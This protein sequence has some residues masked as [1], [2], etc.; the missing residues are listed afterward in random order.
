MGL[1]GRITKRQS[2]EDPEDLDFD[3]ETVDSLDMPGEE[4]GSRGGILR[5][6]S[7]AAPEGGVGGR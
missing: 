3:D 1:L 2:A 4:G 5:Q 6:G 7:K